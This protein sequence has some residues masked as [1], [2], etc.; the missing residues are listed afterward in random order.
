MLAV[1][2]APTAILGDNIGFAIGRKGGRTLFEMPGPLY[3]LRIAALRQGEPFFA[4]HGPKAVFLGRWV[5]GLRVASA[6]LAGINRME[7]PRFLVW[8]ALGGIC[9]AATVGFGAYFVG[10]AFE[11]IIGVG[12]LVAVGVVTAVL[13]AAV[14]ARGLRGRRTRGE[15]T[16]EE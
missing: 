9:W 10:H 4:R 3:D 5:A 11:R 7:W 8:N 12:G 2:A 1:L 14:L 6:W 15:P 16:A 13:L